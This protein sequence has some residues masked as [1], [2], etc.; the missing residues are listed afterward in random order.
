M[1]Y[2]DPSADA[3]DAFGE[4]VAVMRRLLGPGGCPWDR[5]QTLASLRPY[6][7]EETCEV[8]D[9]I[10]RG[11]PAEH[12]EELG[13][14][15]MQIVFQSEIEANQGRFTLAD[16]ARGISE[17]LVRRHPHVFGGAAAESAG[18][19]EAQ[20]EAI[21]ARE[22]EARGSSAR[23]RGA[24]A[25]IPRALPAL[26]RAQKVSRRAA[27]AGFD[28]ESADGCRAKVDE[29]L[30]EIEEARRGRDPAAVE[31][32]IGDALYALVSFSRRLGVDAEI[33]LRGA[34]ERFEG[35]FRRM[36]ETL[37]RSGLS[38]AD[39]PTD[40]LESQWQRAKAEGGDGSG[41]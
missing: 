29:E 18:E 35:R 11:D 34:T 7:L 5:E 40:E 32:E 2:R 6:L 13:D 12:C 23:E 20:W 31:A 38:P 15:L 39:L 41:G 4:L 10:D 1:T 30:E 9:A 22:K 24:L 14:L 33:A 26:A 16:V 28:W 3:A 27:E 19:V 36:E 8:L 21:K 25:G 37:E 17:K